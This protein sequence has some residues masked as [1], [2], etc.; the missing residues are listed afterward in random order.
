MRAVRACL[1]CRLHRLASSPAVT[2]RADIPLAESDRALFRARVYERYLST[3]Y[4]ALREPGDEDYRQNARVLR[5]VL[6]PHLPRDR[7]AAI[8]DAACGIGYAL[9]MLQAEGYASAVGVD[10]SPEQVKA[11]Q[12]R[13]L[14]VELGDAFDVLARQQGRLDVILAL[15]FVEH[16]QRDELLRFFDLARDA[17]RPGGRVIVKTANASS[18]IGLRTRYGDI[19]HEMIFTEKSLRQVFDTCG[20]RPVTIT[21]ERFLPFTVKGW[22]RWFPARLC[23]L[24]WKAYLIAELSEE[25][26]GIATEFNLIGVAERA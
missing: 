8:L 11:A 9:E 25:G 12:S 16:L 7:A 24:V 3:C 19:T 18:L 13:G 17:L 14:P 10:I 4:G 26:L 2:P 22:L 6:L 15:D 1:Q 23:R 20:L 21:G 5:Q